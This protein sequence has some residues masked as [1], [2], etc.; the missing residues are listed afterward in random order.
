MRAS[1]KPVVLVPALLALPLA[2][3]CGGGVR[4]F[5]LR[6]P[7]WKDN[8]TTPFVASC[9]PDPKPDPKDPPN[10][11][12]CMPEEYKSGFLWDGAD[13]IVFRPTARFFAVDPAGESA[14]VNSMDEVPDSSW[15]TNRIG[16]TPM[17]PEEVVR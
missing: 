11:K 1:A 3:G 9:R 16:K 12:I 4:R 2:L 7:L 14:N 5:P 13:N 6:E 10:H 17:T 15:F 8:D